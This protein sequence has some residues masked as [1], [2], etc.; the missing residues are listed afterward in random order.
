MDDSVPDN[1]IVETEKEILETLDHLDELEEKEEEEKA[2]EE[3]SSIEL[4]KEVEDSINFFVRLKIERDKLLPIEYLNRFKILLIGGR[5]WGQKSLRV[6][7][8]ADPYVYYTLTYKVGEVGSILDNGYNG[9]VG[10][11]QKL[12]KMIVSTLV[13]V[14]RDRFPV[15]TP[16]EIWVRKAKK[17]KKL[18]KA[19]YK[20]DAAELFD[21][22]ELG[23][24][25]ATYET[26]IVLV[27]RYTGHTETFIESGKYD[28]HYLSTP[29]KILLS[30]HI[31]MADS[32]R[33]GLG[34]DEKEEL[35]DKQVDEFVEKEKVEK[36]LDLGNK[37]E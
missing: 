15:F 5:S 4:L 10:E 14:W 30:E 20:K 28:P 31:R 32:E 1:I 26:K 18:F 29:N 12:R 24:C 37:Y 7:T 23:R 35:L 34:L 8:E 33:F 25:S 16:Q 2:V 36:K 13:S 9:H 11:V 21:L 6:N 27:D 19:R 17:S 3:E 22:I